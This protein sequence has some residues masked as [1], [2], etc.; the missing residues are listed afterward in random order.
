MK[1]TTIIRDYIVNKLNEYVENGLQVNDSLLLKTIGYYS[2]NKTT[3]DNYVT[4][5]IN[6]DKEYNYNYYTNFIYK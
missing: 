6:Y 1:R 2:I 3:F 5:K 4:Y